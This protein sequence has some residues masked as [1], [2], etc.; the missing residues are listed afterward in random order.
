MRRGA[1]RKSVRCFSPTRM[2]VISFDPGVTTGIAVIGD[3]GAVLH[4]IACSGDPLVV[5]NEII[6]LKQKFPGSRAVAEKPPSLSGN[7]RQHTQQIE[8]RIRDAFPSV[9]WVQPSEWKGHPA[10]KVSDLRGKTQHEKD[11]AGLGRW[12]RKTRKCQESAPT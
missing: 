7:Y 1:Y 6:V 3:E 10:S 5:E 11:A 9:E 12:F 8:E 4:T 2:T